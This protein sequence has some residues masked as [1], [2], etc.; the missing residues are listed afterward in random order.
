MLNRVL[1]NLAW[2]SVV[3]IST[4]VWSDETKIKIKTTAELIQMLQ[5][6]GLVV[7]MPHGQIHRSLFFSAN[8]TDP[9]TCSERP[10]LSDK[11]QLQMLK[12]GETIAELQLPINQVFSSPYCQTRDTAKAVFGKYQIDPELAY[13]SKG[14]L[15]QDPKV[16]QYLK[17]A[18]LNTDTEE[19]NT[20]FVGHSANLINGLGIWPKPAGVAV[21]F[22]KTED[23]I[24]LLGMIKP[25]EWQDYYA[26]L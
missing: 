21:I 1:L 25:D 7:Y 19:G 15:G 13:S 4:T 11:S 20:V 8:Q 23:N 5:K 24:I 3:F 22:K 17:Q 26:G 14:A 12:V 6:G 10:S 2:I 9:L 18:M 16:G